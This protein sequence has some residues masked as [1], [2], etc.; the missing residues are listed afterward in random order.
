MSRRVEEEA[1]ARPRKP[2]SQGGASRDLLIIALDPLHFREVDATTNRQVQVQPGVANRCLYRAILPI[3]LGTARLLLASS[4]DW[5]QWSG[6]KAVC[7]VMAFFACTPGF[8]ANSPDG[9]Q[10]AEMVSAPPSKSQIG[11]KGGSTG[12]RW[13]WPSSLAH[14]P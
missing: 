10:P 6:I 13:M 3:L 12:A 11:R 1:G 8:S 5:V 2:A 4:A 14:Q 9:V 7:T